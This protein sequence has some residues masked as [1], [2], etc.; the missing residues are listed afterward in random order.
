M[1]INNESKLSLDKNKNLDNESEEAEWTF[2]L[3][4]LTIIYERL[5]KKKQAETF[6]SKAIS[7]VSNLGEVPELFYSNTNKPNENSPLGWS[8][9]LFI[10]ALYNVNHN[11]LKLKS[12]GKRIRNV[13]KK[14]S[15]KKTKKSKFVG[16]K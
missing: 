13:N 15:K 4:W 9:S 16:V 2:G 6:L 10:T 3:S 14:V 8:E 7:A 1:N 5:G 11:H 12:T